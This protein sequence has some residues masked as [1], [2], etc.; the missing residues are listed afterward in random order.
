MANVHLCRCHERD[1]QGAR[2]GNGLSEWQIAELINDAARAVLWS[3]KHWVVVLQKT[4][5][6]RITGINSFVRIAT[7]HSIAV[8][9]HC[10]RFDDPDR[11]G[12]FAMAWRASQDARLLGR[13]L[14][15]QMDRERPDAMNHGLCLCDS[16]RHWIDTHKEYPGKKKGFLCDVQCPSV[17][18]ECCHLSNPTD[19]EWIK[20]ATNQRK[21]GR[22]VGRG[23]VRYLDL[24]G[25]GR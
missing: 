1:D 16:E 4:L 14:L 17:I 21:V 12:H 15:E 23:I 24:K 18:L 13:C 25:V 8:E 5:A 19:A 20:D 6:E 3:T 2:I 11:S 9:T 7:K 10:N 22:A